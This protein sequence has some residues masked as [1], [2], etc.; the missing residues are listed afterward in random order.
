MTIFG[1]MMTNRIVFLLF[2]AFF[3]IE[4]VFS[5]FAVIRATKTID[6]CLPPSTDLQS[7]SKWFSSDRTPSI[8]L[9]LNPG[10]TSVQPIDGTKK[11]TC[12][13]KPIQF[14]G[15]LISQ[16]LEFDVDFDGIC[17]RT[18]LGDD[19]SQLSFE[20]QPFLVSII[21]KL[22]PKVK[23]CTTINYDVSVGTIGLTSVLELNFGIPLWFPIPIEKIEKDVSKTMEENMSADLKVLLDKICMEYEKSEEATLT[24]N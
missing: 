7:F 21:S 6:R 10:L 17:V 23:S 15:V 19:S 20:G 13:V 22:I 4:V 24:S 3:L 18:E 16:T 12:Q 9:S 5:K 1:G 8:V 2:V 14:P 11:Y